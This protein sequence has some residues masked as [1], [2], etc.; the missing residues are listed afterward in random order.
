MCCFSSLPD[1]LKETEQYY[2]TSL[3]HLE[4]NVE[5]PFKIHNIGRWS[6]Q[7]EYDPKY[8]ALGDLH[9]SCRGWANVAIITTVIAVAVAVFVAFN[10]AVI[11]TVASLAAFSISIYVY[12]YCQRRTLLKEFGL[13]AVAK[14]RDELLQLIKVPTNFPSKSSAYDDKCY[15]DAERA[16]QEEWN[17]NFNTKQNLKVAIIFKY[18]G[19]LQVDHPYVVAVVEQSKKIE[20]QRAANLIYGTEEQSLDEITA[21]A[22]AALRRQQKLTTVLDP[23]ATAAASARVELIA[24]ADDSDP[25]RIELMAQMEKETELRREICRQSRET[26]DKENEPHHRRGALQKILEHASSQPVA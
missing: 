22:E 2:C 25:K 5:G 3:Y 14:A 21:Q 19:S 6:S 8:H 26:F 12:R 11:A 20:M 7:A 17:K 24:F 15:Y 4:S 9:R 16:V 13:Q 18:Q 10:I 1:L 23:K